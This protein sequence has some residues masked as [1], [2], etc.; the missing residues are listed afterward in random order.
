MQKKMGKQGRIY[1]AN[2][3]GLYSGIQTIGWALIIYEI[4]KKAIE[5]P[6]DIVEFGCWKGNNLLFMAKLYHF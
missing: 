6:G 5:I 4:L 1:V 2:H 3:F